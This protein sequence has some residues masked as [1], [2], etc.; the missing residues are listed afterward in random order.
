MAALIGLLYG[1]WAKE[2]ETLFALFETLNLVV[3]APALIYLF[4]E[5]PRG[6][7]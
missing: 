6:V 5:W 2:T 1:L 3:F 4:P 7:A